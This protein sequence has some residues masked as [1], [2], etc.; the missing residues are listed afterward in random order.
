VDAH[1]DCPT[2]AG[3]V[4][5]W[6]KGE[7]VLRVTARKDEYGEAVD[8][9]CND[10]RFHKKS[11]SDWTIEGIAKINRH[12]VISHNHQEE[13]RSIQLETRIQQRM[14]EGSGVKV[15]L[16]EG[17]LNPNNVTP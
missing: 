10:C 16:G 13:L 9:I 7:D 8:W 15:G 5:L 11:V 14:L 2:C 4:R 3:K 1:R 12:S 17:A 6:F